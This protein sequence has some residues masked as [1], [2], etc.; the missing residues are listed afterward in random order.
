MNKLVLR[1]VLVIKDGNKFILYKTNSREHLLPV[2]S[3]DILIDG[4]W[5]VF[6]GTLETQTYFEN[7][8]R[9]KRYFGQGSLTKSDS[10]VFTNDFT[11]LGTVV[12]LFE[13]RK[14]PVTNR[15]VVDFVVAK[16][17]NYFN[18][19]A[20]GSTAEFLL[21]NKKVGDS[22]SLDSA[23]FQSRAYEKNGIPQIAYEVCIRS[24]S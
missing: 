1:G 20:F 12:K 7:D 4:D 8:K 15:R 11:L 23:S 10:N 9:R 22:I 13:L 17:N 19:I 14:T 16:G 21:S 18:C 6:D 24:F 3:D 5:V 2:K